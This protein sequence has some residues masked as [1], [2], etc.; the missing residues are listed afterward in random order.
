VSP[1]RPQALAELVVLRPGAQAGASPPPGPMPLFA[2][3]DF[4]RVAGDTLRPGGLALTRRGLALAALPPGSLV[5][6]LGC[7]R[8][9]TA[10]L[11][12]QAGHRVLALDLAAQDLRSEAFTAGGP[13]T[14]EPVSPM[15][16][17]RTP[18]EVAAGLLVLRARVQALPLP[19]ASLD[20]AFC[21]CVLSATGAAQAV[22]AEAA[23]ALKPGGTLVLSDL[24]LRDAPAQA[25]GIGLVQAKGLAAARAAGGLAQGTGGGPA[26]RAEGDPAQAAD[27]TPSQA[28]DDPAQAG[29]IGLV[30]AKG[31]GLMRAAGGLAQGTGDGSVESAGGCLSGA[32][33]HHELLHAL[34]RA[35]FQVS[36]FEDHSRLLAELAGRLLFAGLP[37][38]ALGFATSE[39]H[40]EG[41]DKGRNEAKANAHGGAQS[42]CGCAG[43]RP[44]YFLCLAHKRAQ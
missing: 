1:Q 42:G 37:R 7:G 34:D 31:L 35:G 14:L 43:A 11:L 13:A 20:A 38:S 26:Q 9:A 30:Q 23:R 4:R 18:A 8:G 25:G 39:A 16:T 28:T 10:R 5:A 21:E 36:H 3:E 22:L 2:R 32:L 12:T 44:G 17:A 40:G 15:Q 24:Y 33:P 27:S 29:D 6:D 19:P 41:R